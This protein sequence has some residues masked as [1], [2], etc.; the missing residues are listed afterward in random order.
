LANVELSAMLFVISRY[1]TRPDTLA[2]RV[3]ALRR[4]RWP[5]L[6]QLTYSANPFPDVV[7]AIAKN[8][9]VRL[10]LRKKSNGRF[11]NKSS[12]V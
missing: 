11:V 6:L 5:S 10:A 8:Y 2:V 4:F 3:R 1:S 9:A 12:L 7:G